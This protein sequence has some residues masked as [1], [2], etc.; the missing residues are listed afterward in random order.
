M[1]FWVKGTFLSGLV[2]T[3]ELHVSTVDT[4]F[5]FVHETSAA[6]KAQ[7]ATATTNANQAN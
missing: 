7:S 1:C 3:G 2:S 4:C 6:E 5:T